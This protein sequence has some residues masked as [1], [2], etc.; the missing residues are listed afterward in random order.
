MTICASDEKIYLWTCAP[1]E[2]SYQPAY[3][4]ARLRKPRTFGCP[5]NVQ[6]KLTILHGGGVFEDVRRYLFLT[7]RGNNNNHNRWILFLV[8]NNVH[9]YSSVAIYFVLH[10][11]KIGRRGYRNNEDPAEPAEPCNLIKAFLYPDMFYIQCSDSSAESEGPDQTAQMRRLIGPALSDY[12]PKAPFSMVR[13]I[14]V[15][16]EPYCS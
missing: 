2:D 10:H 16:P 5:Q 1:I 9:W 13:L 11:E 12:V 6:Q 14:F 8:R 15:K 4:A 3:P 7:L